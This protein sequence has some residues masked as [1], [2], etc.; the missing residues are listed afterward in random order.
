M[1]NPHEQLIALLEW[2]D[3]NKELP[4][5]DCMVLVYEEN[6]P[7]YLW[8]GDKREMHNCQWRFLNLEDL[9]KIVKVSA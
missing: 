1:N 6:S 5:S 4:E 2:H 9:E 8:S 3:A 7:H